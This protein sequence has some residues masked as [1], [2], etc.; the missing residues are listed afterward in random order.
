MYRYPIRVAKY[1]AYLTILFFVIFGML[2]IVGYSNNISLYDMIFSSQGLMLLGAVVIFSL[3]Y[4][5]FGFLNRDLTF[6]ATKHIEKVEQ[7]MA[8]CG[9]KRRDGDSSEA[10]IFEPSTKAKNIT[11]LY[12][13]EIRIDTTDG[14]SS[15]RGPRREVVRAYFRMGTFIA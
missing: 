5:F 12:E 15:I 14:R 1:C 4:P 3:L 7:V 11:L 2:N 10:M 13:G 8:M 6:D 9:Y